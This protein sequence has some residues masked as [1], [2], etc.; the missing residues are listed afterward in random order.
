MSMR[1]NDMHFCTISNYF[2]NT[3]FWK[4]RVDLRRSGQEKRT[5][6][7]DRALKGLIG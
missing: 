2:R 5:E 7:L 6:L 4:T 3:T 1:M